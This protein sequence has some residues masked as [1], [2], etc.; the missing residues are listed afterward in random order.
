MSEPAA[1]DIQTIIRHLEHR[2]QRGERCLVGVTGPPGVGKST[3]VADLASRF[4]PTP[5]I[6]G[7]DA[8]HLGHQHLESIGQVHRKGAHHTFDAWGYVATLRR[9]VKQGPDEAVYVPRFDRSIED[10][11]AAAVPI[12]D[13]DQLILTEGN[14]L[15]LDIPPWNQLRDLLSLTVYLDLEEEVRLDRLVRRHVEFGKTQEH[16]VRHV[17]ESDQLNAHLIAGSRHHADYVVVFE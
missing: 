6:V 17:H 4:D 13:S 5:P 1:G 9:I 16:A 3:F 15:L 7:M 14:Y 12:T 8:F 10:S 11:I 2:L